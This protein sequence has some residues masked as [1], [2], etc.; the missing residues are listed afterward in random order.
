LTEDP[1]TSIVNKWFGGVLANNGK[2]YGIPANSTSI[3]IIDPVLNFPS[4]SITGLPADDNKWNGGVL[5]KNGKIYGIPA[6]STSILIID[7]E[8]N[9]ADTTTITGLSAD[10]GKWQG[11]VLAPNGQIFGI[12]FNREFLLIIDPET[13]LLNEVPISSQ[14]LNESDTSS[15]MNVLN[16][17]WSGGVLAPNGMIYGIPFNSRVILVINPN[18]PNAMTYISLDTSLYGGT[19]TKYSKWAGGVLAPSGMIYGI[20]LSE[21]SQGN[22]LKIDPINEITSTINIAGLPVDTKFNWYGGL[23]APDGKIYGIPYDS[24]SV[25]IINPDND[26][27]N[28]I[29]IQGIFPDIH[30]C[31]GGVLAPNGRIYGIPNKMDNILNIATS[32]PTLPNWML[33]A[34]FNKF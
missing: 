6:N 29:N 13:N 30:K 24:T 15:D 2:I 18:E 22:V 21:N 31:I 8:T 7:P 28:I 33:Q 1:P 23:L 11:G 32:L 3:L 10:S 4:V 16:G 27:T 19:T 25:L 34:Y 26:T 17:G 9:T 20:P 14:I 12:P 5:A